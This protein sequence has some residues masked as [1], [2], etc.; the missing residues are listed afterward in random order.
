[1]QSIININQIQIEGY[2]CSGIMFNGTLSYQKN[3]FNSSFQNGIINLLSITDMNLTNI[4]NVNGIFFSSS[5]FIH[6]TE[7]FGG[8]IN[9]YL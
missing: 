1:M 9:Y 4:G 2:L 5:S 3:K 8:I 7:N 6:L